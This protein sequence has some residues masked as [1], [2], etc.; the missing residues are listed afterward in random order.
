VFPSGIIHLETPPRPAEP[1]LIPWVKANPACRRAV[2]FSGGCEGKM[3]QKKAEARGPVYCLGPE[4]PVR[5]LKH[6]LT[7]E[8]IAPEA[9]LQ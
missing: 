2:N 6:E 3:A 1:E 5:T 8:K 9:A 7:M 4:L